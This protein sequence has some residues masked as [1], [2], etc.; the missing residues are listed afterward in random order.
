MNGQPTHLGAVG[1]ACYRTELPSLL[2]AKISASCLLWPKLFFQIGEQPDLDDLVRQ[3]RALLDANPD[4]LLA[5]VITLAP[6]TNWAL[7]HPQEMTVYSPRLEDVLP[8]NPSRSPEPSWASQVW[9]EAAASFLQTTVKHLHEAL[10]GRIVL[11]QF[12][13]GKCGENYPAPD[14]VRY[15]QWY[16]SDYSEPMHA[17]FRNWLRSHY[18]SRDAL[19]KAWGDEHV[20]F[21]TAAVPSREELL[22]SD[23]FSFRSPTRSQVT[24]Y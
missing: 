8:V 21:E 5:V 18:S 23:W 15:N 4:A 11:Y 9:R 24:D 6:S 1:R 22:I 7:A 17:W 12:G 3:F 14:P 16:C 13:S 19:R 2:G 10:E 20:D